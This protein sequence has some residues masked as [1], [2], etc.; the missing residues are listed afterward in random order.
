VDEG[1]LQRGWVEQA[2]FE[3]YDFLYA[4]LPDRQE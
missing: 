3:L 1:K 4:H 2:S